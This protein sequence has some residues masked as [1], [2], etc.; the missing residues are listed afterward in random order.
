MLS[1]FSWKPT[2]VRPCARIWRLQRWAT[3]LLAFMTMLHYF[4]PIRLAKRRRMILSCFARDGTLGHQT[5]HTHS[6]WWERQIIQSMFQLHLWNKLPPNWWLKT[7]I[8]HAPSD[9][10]VKVQK[11]G[12][13]SRSNVWG[14]ELETL[15]FR[16]G[17]I[18]RLTHPH[19]FEWFMLLDTL[20]GLAG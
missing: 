4:M 17:I 1:V 7:I 18:W 12:S 16:A 13:L 20:A 8:S 14:Q 5:T 11:A 9:P 19:V 10:R 3:S 15:R 2:C 6:F